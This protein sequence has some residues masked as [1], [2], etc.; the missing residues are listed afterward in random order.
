[1]INKLTLRTAATIAQG[2]I[3]NGISFLTAGTKTVNGWVY[4]TD[5]IG[6]YSTQYM[7]RAVVAHIG[8]A[9]N[10]PLDAVYCNGYND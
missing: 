3:N 6:N 9:A 10:L 2:I 7:F 5:T 1:M 8:L 4:K